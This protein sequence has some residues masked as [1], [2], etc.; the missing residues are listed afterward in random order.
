MILSPARQLVPEPPERRECRPSGSYPQQGMIRIALG[1]GLLALAGLIMFVA[2]TPPTDAATIDGG[3]GVAAL[4][5][6]AGTILIVFGRN[7]VKRR[8]HQSDQNP[9]D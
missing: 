9:H 7:A 3:T 1:G 2:F 8:L 6:I 4:L 5:A